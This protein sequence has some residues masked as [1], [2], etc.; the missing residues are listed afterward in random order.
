MEP[1]VP[2]PRQ[3]LEIDG[4]V[5]KDIQEMFDTAWHRFKVW[6]M[7]ILVALGLAC[8]AFSIICTIAFPQQFSAKNWM[9]FICSM[10]V[11]GT[12]IAVFGLWML[13]RDRK[14]RT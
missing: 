3:P 14:H 4:N 5:L 1:D 9:H 13:L 6:M 2:K 10:F 12:A 7:V 11:F 8:V